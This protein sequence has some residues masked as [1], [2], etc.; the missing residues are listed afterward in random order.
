MNRYAI[1]YSG[2][3]LKRHSEG[4]YRMNGHVLSTETNLFYKFFE[5]YWDMSYKS[6]VILF[7]I[8]NPAE[9]YSDS[10]AF[11]QCTAD[12]ALFFSRLSK[13]FGATYLPF[14]GNYSYYVCN[15]ADI[16]YNIW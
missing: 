1:L 15:K 16:G 14:K 2:V 7:M 3:I 8:N 9:Y 11:Y 10:Y 4:R 5:G 12:F 6:D 13:T